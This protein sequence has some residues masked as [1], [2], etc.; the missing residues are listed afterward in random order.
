MSVSTHVLNTAVG[1]SA[2]GVPVQL[3]S[4]AVDGSWEVRGCERTDADG[5]FCDWLTLG[6][7]VHR[8]VFDTAK[9]SVFYPEGAVAFTITDPAAHHHISLL[10][11]PFLYSTYR[12]S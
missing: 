2:K 4:R 7:G 6:L 8:L 11:R 10:L 1:Q 9:I 12:G 5:R 3:E